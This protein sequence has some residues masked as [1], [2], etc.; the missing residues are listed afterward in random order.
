MTANES[1]Q[2]FSSPSLDELCQESGGLPDA[3]AVER[4]NFDC[5]RG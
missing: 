3:A 2:M 1:Q 4:E 5:V